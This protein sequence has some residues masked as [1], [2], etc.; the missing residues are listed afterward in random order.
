M[1]VILEALKKLER[2]KVASRGG[3]VDI[4]PGILSPHKRRSASGKWSLAMVILAAVCLTAV[5]TFFVMGHIIA[6]NR[7]PAPFAAPVDRGTIAPQQSV[8]GRQIDQKNN[9]DEGEI[10]REAPEK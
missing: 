4:V 3:A 9:V 6:D 2:E 5:A 10:V 8:V 7:Q 1:S